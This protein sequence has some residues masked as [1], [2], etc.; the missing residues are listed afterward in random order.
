M[1]KKEDKTNVMRVLEQV[2]KALVTRGGCIL[3]RVYVLR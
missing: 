1:A 3:A 2:F